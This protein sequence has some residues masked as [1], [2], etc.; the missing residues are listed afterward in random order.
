MSGKIEITL[1]GLGSGRMEC[2]SFK[3]RK[4]PVVMTK[5][6]YILTV[7]QYKKDHSEDKNRLHMRL[8]KTHTNI[9]KYIL[10]KCHG[11]QE[12]AELFLALCKISPT[13]QSV[14]WDQVFRIHQYSIKFFSESWVNVE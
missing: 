2:I 7:D 8:K 10:A 6:G 3:K 4:N 9:Q 1:M 5:K 11:D 12:K 13:D 14:T